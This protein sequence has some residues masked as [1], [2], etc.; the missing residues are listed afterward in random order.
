MKGFPL[1]IIGL[2]LSCQSCITQKLD[3]T[4]YPTT[5]YYQ[6]SKKRIAELP[7]ISSSSNDTIQV[8]WFKIN[9]T[10]PK[11]VPMAGYGKRKGKKYEQVHDSVWVRAFV[12]RK[13]NYKAA[14]VTADLLIMPMRITERLQQLLVNKGY[15]LN[16]IYLTAT[17]THYSFGGWGKKLAGRIIAGKYNQELVNKTTEAIAQTI[18]QAENNATTA[19]IGYQEIPAPEFVYNRLVGNK[20][21]LDT[22]IRVMHFQKISGEKALICTFAA[23][24]T[25]VASN[26]L[27]LSAEYPGALVSLL[28]QKMQLNMAA[29]GAGAVGSHGPQAPGENYTKVANLAE[30]LANKIQ[31]YSQNLSLTFQTD[32]SNAYFAI[33]LNKPQWRYGEKRR[34]RPWLFYTVF[35]KYPAGL[36]LLQVGSTVFIG[37]PCDFSGEL[38]PEIST[39]ASARNQKVVVTSFNG[40]YI[41]YVTP[42][43]YFNHKKYETH[44]MNF[45]GPS[46]GTYLTELIKLILQKTN[47]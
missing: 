29:F 3:T 42:E 27:R 44:D 13:G 37:T 28:E 22:L 38:L 24:P 21:N 23:H 16:N 45:F 25:S 34:F 8:G 12:F 17:H 35:G 10:P 4:P 31:N 18:E 40:S 47:K 14:W 43:K 7:L 2:L 19:S 33:D 36:S 15:T 5:Q 6:Q 41:G 46:T 1:F 9:M 11:P 30:G 39:T 32:L 20:G 26:D